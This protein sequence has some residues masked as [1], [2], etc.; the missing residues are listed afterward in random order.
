MKGTKRRVGGAEGVSSLAREGDLPVKECCLADLHTM[1]FTKDFRKVKPKNKPTWSSS[2]TWGTSLVVEGLRIHLPI[3]RTWVWSLGQK[4]PH[5]A[6][7]LSL[8][9][10]YWAWELE[11]E[12]SCCYPQLQKTL[13]QQRRTSTPK[14]N[15]NPGQNKST[16]FPNQRTLDAMQTWM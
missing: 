15:P 11:L 3:Q 8:C 7:P 9:T 14:I 1:G 5:A 12:S 10:T 6:E 13:Q 2:E 16:G 4:I